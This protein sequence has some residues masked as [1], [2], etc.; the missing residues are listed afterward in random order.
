MTYETDGTPIYDRAVSSAPLRK[1]LKKLFSDGIMPNPST[2]MQVSAGEGMNVIVSPGFAIVNGCMKLEEAQR[3]LAIQAANTTYDR[4]DT[5]VLRLNDNDSVRSCDFYIL[6]GTPATSPVR[7]TLTRSESIFEIGLADLF[8]AKN[9]S[10]ISSQ[11]ITDTRYETERCGVISSVSQFDTT[12]LYNQVQADLSSFQANEQAAILTWFE[13]MKDQLS[14]DA[15]ANL[16]LQIGTLQNLSTTVKENL[17]EAINE[18][19]VM[20]Q[21]GGKNLVGDEFSIDKAYAVGDYCIYENVLYKFTSEKESGAW[22]AGKVTSTTCA[23]EFKALNSKFP[24]PDYKNVVIIPTNTYTAE[25]DGYVSVH[26]TRASYGTNGVACLAMIIVN[27]LEVARISIQQAGYPSWGIP[28]VPIK[29]GDIVTFYV[30]G[31]GYSRY[32]YPIR[33]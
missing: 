11:R 23:D 5:V 32:F 4:I 31:E 13:N 1:L 10:V 28:P 30:D 33:V 9:T 29:A 22:D 19:F 12:T 25:T 3:T 24:A 15:A 17:V 20:A 2:N 21:N 16:Q 27:G 26:V 6:E 8:I 18:L 14:A 7:P